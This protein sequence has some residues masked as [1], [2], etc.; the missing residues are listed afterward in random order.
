MLVSLTTYRDLSQFW[1]AAPDLFD[2]ATQAKFE[3]ADSQLAPLF[4]GRDFAR[5]FLGSFAADI[6]LV[7]TRQHFDGGKQ[8]SPDIKLPAFALVFRLNA[9]EKVRRSL[10]ASF[11]SIV[12]FANVAG[13]Q[14]GQ[15][16]LELESAKQGDTEL[17]TATYLPPD[18]G[19]AKQAG[20][21]N[22]NFSPAMALI[23]DRFILASTQSLAREL[24]E[25]VP[26]E[27]SSAQ[28]TTGRTTNTRIVSDL[29]VAKDVLS[30]N[31]PQ[32]I[33]QNML[34][35]GH[36]REQAER[37]IGILLELL[38]YLRGAALEL[39][40]DQQAIRLDLGIDLSG[41]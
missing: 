35:K 39:S 15:P 23:A 18:D 37:E 30:D 36:D 3:Q 16:Q 27:S 4:S 25:L 34:E 11:Q 6:Q 40:S 21:I 22:Y 7:A 14:F 10:K 33:A 24:A 9:P 31:R 32:L 19:D 20:K 1:A 28:D 29:R 38:G 8:P 17:V 13:S 26:K 12:G 41:K 2:D 5:D